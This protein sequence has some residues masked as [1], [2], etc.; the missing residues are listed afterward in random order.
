MKRLLSIFFICLSITSLFTACS[1]SLPKAQ[2]I[3]VLDFRLGEGFME[4][5]GIQV[6]YPLD[7]LLG[8]PEGDNNPVAFILHGAHTITDV[9]ESRYYLG[10]D[11]LVEALTKAGYLTLSININRAFVSEPVEGVE[12]ERVFNIFKGYYELLEKANA[13]EKIFAYDLT[14]KANLDQ[15]NFIGHSRGGDNSLYISKLLKDA[16]DERVQS[17]LMVAPPQN[18]VL[19]ETY[20]DLPTGII[21]PQYD[22]DVST[23]DGATLFN[24][25]YQLGIPRKHPIASAFLYGGNHAQFN[26][27]LPERD[28]LV[29][30]EDVTYLPAQ[31]QKDF[32]IQYA[33][34]FLNTFNRSGVHSLET[35]GIIQPT[36]YSTPF[37]PSLLMSE[38]YRLVMPTNL[39]EL[40]SAHYSMPSSN[41]M[42]VAYVT[43]SSFPEEDTAAPFNHP[44][45]LHGSIPL[46][47]LAWQ[48]PDATLTFSLDTQNLS[49]YKQLALWIANDSTHPYNDGNNPLE[50]EVILTDV[51]GLTASKVLSATRDSALRYNPTPI[52]NIHADIDGLDPYW[53]AQHFTP[54][55]TQFIP[56]THFSG[57]DL[58]QI[59]SITLKGLNPS[60][61]VMLGGIDLYE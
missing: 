1:K 18:I 59:T 7:G 29:F 17:V 26:T 61:A 28:M 50:L 20:V 6:P 12:T 2:G 38:G 52:I 16:G 40:S 31:T 41:K 30:Y 34:D 45:G 14:D 51:K 27:Q 43:L 44:V 5:N 15:L 4:E 48:T 37:M 39:V 19:S 21:L 9:N 47:S 10:F 25:A 57:I 58:T 46:Y 8:I 23:L 54:L 60:G 32:L 33:T 35:L 49:N 22:G 55:G 42:D 53:K 36:A 56:L 13:G 11:Y 3:Q 24:Y